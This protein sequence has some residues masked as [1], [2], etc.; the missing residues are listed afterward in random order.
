MPDTNSQLRQFFANI[1]N[2][3]VKFIFTALYIVIFGV[4]SVLFLMLIYWL[5]FGKV[6]LFKKT[7]CKNK[8]IKNTRHFLPGFLLFDFKLILLLK[9]RQE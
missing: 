4:P 9:S 1:L 6:G 7:L 3:F 8:K 2:F 5:G